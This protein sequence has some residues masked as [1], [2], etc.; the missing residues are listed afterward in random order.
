[1]EFPKMVRVKQ[2]FKTNPIQNLPEK[3]RSEV[4]KVAP[5]KLISSGEECGDYCRQPRHCKHR[6]CSG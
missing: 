2:D 1:M 5:E 3:V 4:A 6:D